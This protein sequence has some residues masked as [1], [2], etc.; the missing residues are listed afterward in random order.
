M[1]NKK[2]LKISKYLIKDIIK[3]F[4]FTLILFFVVEH[5]GEFQYHKPSPYYESSSS[6]YYVTYETLFEN[7]I[8]SD[9]IF[10]TENKYPKIADIEKYFDK[11]PYYINAIFSDYIPFIICLI[12]LLLLR[13]IFRKYKFTIA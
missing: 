13:I 12:F 10:F 4:F 6:D 1:E 8:Y 11:L 3:S 9:S 2:E 7:K 5:F